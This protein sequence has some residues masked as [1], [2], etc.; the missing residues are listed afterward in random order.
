MEGMRG[1]AVFFVFIVHYATLVDP[2]LGNGI[3]AHQIAVILR[4]IG[5]S[6]VDLF[7]VLS[8]YLIYGLLMRR[9]VPFTKYIGRR[10]QRI[11]PAF[12]AVFALYLILSVSYPEESKLPADTLTASVYIVQNMLLLPGLID[13]EPIITVAWSLSYEV[14]Y[15]LVIPL[16]IFLTSMRKWQ[17]KTRVQFFATVT[18]AGFFFCAINGGHIRLLMFVAGILLYE[19]VDS[20]TVK[21][22]PLLG[23]IA[24]SIAV[25]T[26][27]VLKGIDA[28]ETWRFVTLYICFFLLCLECFSS[29]GVVS[30]IFSW[31]PLRW[32]GNM[33]YS[34]YLIHGLTLKAAFM[35][36]AVAYP[37]PG[38]D[39]LFLVLL[40][41]MFVISIIPATILFVTVEKRFS[42]IGR[43]R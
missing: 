21:T 31:T 28:N 39:G 23:L 22:P 38:W 18:A 29:D 11:Y 15:Y 37:Y 42:L 13:I 2:F 3:L 5:N 33:S 34:Y 17:R 8:G 10:I 30:R 9:H 14:F 6:G 12:L 40:A 7:F 27:P 16:L 43:K 19:A 20:E 24:L 26:M 41:P 4:N 36:L 25:V 1:L 35:L 32:Y